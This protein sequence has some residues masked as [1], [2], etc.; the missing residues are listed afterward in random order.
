MSTI[1]STRTNPFTNFVHDLSDLAALTTEASV[2]LA[3][4]PGVLTVRSYYERTVTVQMKEGALLAWC[5]T[6]GVPHSS[7]VDETDYTAYGGGYTT[8]RRYNAELPN[9]PGGRVL[10][11]SCEVVSTRPA[12]SPES[13]SEQGAAA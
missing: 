9:V 12:V 7:T 11:V 3:G 4:V 1:N 10:L 6:N 5:E 8:H 2:V 13:E